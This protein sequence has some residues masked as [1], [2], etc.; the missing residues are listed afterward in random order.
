MFLIEKCAT[1]HIFISNPATSWKTFCVH[2]HVLV[3]HEASSIVWT[4]NMAKAHKCFT[5]ILV[6]AKLVL[7]LEFLISLK[8]VLLSEHGEGAQVLTPIYCKLN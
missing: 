4:L 8:Q 7:K 3:F 1:L 5:P 6:Q 2:V